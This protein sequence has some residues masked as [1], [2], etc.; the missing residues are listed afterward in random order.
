MMAFTSLQGSSETCLGS[1][2]SPEGVKHQDVPRRGARACASGRI[3]RANLRI[4]NGDGRMAQRSIGAPRRC[5]GHCRR[6][7]EMTR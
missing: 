3:R 1:R 5:W 7:V 2:A 6:S 4:P